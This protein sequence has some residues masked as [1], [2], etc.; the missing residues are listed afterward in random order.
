MEWLTSVFE[1]THMLKQICGFY[2]NY[3][4][5][6]YFFGK[7]VH[8]LA[9]SEV[10]TTPVR[11]HPRLRWLATSVLAQTVP[12]TRFHLEAWLGLIFKCA[13]HFL[14][15]INERI[16]FSDKFTTVWFEPGSR[17]PKLKV[18][19]TLPCTCTYI[20]SAGL[21]GSSKM[22]SVCRDELE[23][24]CPMRKRQRRLQ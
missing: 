20:Y 2:Y 11:S 13:T 10:W 3:T 8:N 12:S 6:S 1:H 5:H 4:D 17:V 19:T 23:V 22:T 15:T 7:K 21:S 14:R 24:D 16:R 18:L 9:W